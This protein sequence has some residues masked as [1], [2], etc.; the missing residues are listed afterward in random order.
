MRSQ[1]RSQPS[2]APPSTSMADENASEP[3]A[4]VESTTLSLQDAEAYALLRCVAMGDCLAFETLYHRYTP[5]LMRYLK[6]RLGES[7][8]AEEVCQDLW[9][10][11]WR[12]ADRAQPLAPLSAWLFEIA[13]R[14]V[15]KAYSRRAP[16]TREASPMPETASEALNPETDRVRQDQRR[17]VARAVATLPPALRQTVTL[18]YIEV[19]RYREI[20]AEMGC[21]VDTVKDRLR[22]ARRR[23]A[24]AL[25]RD[26]R[27]M[28]RRW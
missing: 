22:Q 20:A 11:V 8:W 9:L 1:L 28:A 10:V 2:L 14:L 12:Q 15:L 18:R 27:F 26:E 13:R 17:Q 7:E 21:A 4:T 24:A 19:Y 5:R 25:K 6:L 3:G 16:L 23:L